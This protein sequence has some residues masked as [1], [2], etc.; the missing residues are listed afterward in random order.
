MCYATTANR[1]PARFTEAGV[2]VTA[3]RFLGTIHNFAVIDDLQRSRPAICALRV[4][5]NA[6]R[7]AL[8]G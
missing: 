6:L 5:G 8:H 7:E 2:A 1:I 3:M 4:V